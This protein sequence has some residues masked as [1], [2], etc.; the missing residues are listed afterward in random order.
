M[1]FLAEDVYQKVK[2]EKGLESVHLELWPKCVAPNKTLLEKM[3]AVRTIVSLGLEARAKA[4]I[5]VRQPLASLAIKNDAYADD[6]DLAELIKDELNIKELKS[7]PSMTEEVL[8]DTAMTP[9]LTQEGQARE[10]IRSVQELR[11]KA[12]CDPHEM[13]VLSVDTSKEGREL[14]EKFKADISK[15]AQLSSITFNSL[16]GESDSKEIMQK[17]E[18]K[19]DKLSFSIAIIR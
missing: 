19:V 11:K 9:E 7:N 17:E 18:V 16:S 3:Q 15:T 1:P 14:I 10:F 8:L 5:K 6:Q 13:L 12:K 2:G 4:G